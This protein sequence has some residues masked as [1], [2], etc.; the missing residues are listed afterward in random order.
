MSFKTDRSDFEFR[1]NE[2]TRLIN[3]NKDALSPAMIKGA[4]CLNESYTA[5]I[6]HQ[7]YVLACDVCCKPF[8]TDD[9]HALD[10]DEHSKCGACMQSVGSDV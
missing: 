7:D 2:L 5:L 4:E 9:E 6:S 10:T 8:Y 1:L 3:E